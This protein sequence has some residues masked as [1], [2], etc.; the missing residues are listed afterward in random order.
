[1][2][3]FAGENKAP[4]NRSLSPDAAERTA[5]VLRGN[6]HRHKG[7]GS[8]YY[9]HSKLIVVDDECGNKSKKMLNT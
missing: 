7:H 6:I 4:E 5:T 1:M 3:I 9:A 2:L 8:E